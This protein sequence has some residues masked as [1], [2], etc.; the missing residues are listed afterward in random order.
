MALLLRDSHY[1][2][3]DPISQMVE[4]FVSPALD[5]MAKMSD[6]FYI[7][8]KDVQ[9]MVGAFF[10]KESALSLHGDTHTLYT[11]D[12]VQLSP[13]LRALMLEIDS[14][15]QRYVQNN[16]RISLETESVKFT[17]GQPCALPGKVRISVDP[18]AT[19]PSAV[20]DFFIAELKTVVNPSQVFKEGIKAIVDGLSLDNEILRGRTSQSTSKLLLELS[21]LI[22]EDVWR[23]RSSVVIDQ[24]GV[25]V[26]HVLNQSPG[27][28]ADLASL[29]HLKIMTHSKTPI[30]SFARIKE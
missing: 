13:E 24:M 14:T 27:W 25:C 21:R 2:S 8:I 19:E 28:G 3:M 7:D 15:H 12:L 16:L 10:K 1:E 6:G 20:R 23:I 18:K 26:A 9:D 11:G 29:I 4:P 22:R 17:Y 5:V 30:Y